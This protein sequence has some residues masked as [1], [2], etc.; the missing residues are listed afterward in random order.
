MAGSL[1]AFNSA[2]ALRRVFIPS[3][4][5][6]SNCLHVTRI[7]V[8]ACLPPAQ[9]HQSRAYAGAWSPWNKTSAGTWGAETFKRPPRETVPATPAETTASTTMA[10]QSQPPINPDRPGPR[11]KTKLAR[12]PR[13]EEIRVPYVFVQEM[14]DDGVERLSE[15]QSVR[16]LIK[17][18]NRK[19]ESLQV[20]YEAKGAD[21]SAQEWPIAQIV[22]KKEEL[23]R[24][25]KKKEELK[26]KA[27]TN[28]E[29]E[30]EMN[31]A[32]GPHDVEHKMRTLQGFLA[33]GWK[34]QL[35]LLKKSGKGAK[36]NKT[37]AEELLARILEAVAAVTG[38]K[39]WKGREGQLLG[40]MKLFLQ[41]KLQEE[42]KER[43]RQREMEKE[44]RKEM[45]RE[46]EKEKEMRKQRRLEKE[47]IIKAAE[48]ISVKQTA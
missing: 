6:T 1:C 33:K 17:G 47:A 29:K 3:A 36:A 16:R 27:A 7:F 28:K 2:A 12:L 24:L 40:S 39:E 45:E 32:M 21:W 38:S 43:E 30:L 10:R 48:G 19:T 34:V 35:L 31:W 23:A 20:I 14:H 15:A 11:V 44:K 41:G 26:K 46:R 8:P 5:E 22:N 18:L 37:Q 4:L 42:E 25:Q 9:Q 13:D